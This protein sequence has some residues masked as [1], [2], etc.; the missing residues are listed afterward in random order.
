M[1]AQTPNPGILSPRKRCTQIGRIEILAAT[2][3]CSQLVAR[4]RNLAHRSAMGFGDDAGHPLAGTPCWA[5]LVAHTA[6]LMVSE[7][8][9]S[10]KMHNS[11][12][13]SIVRGFALSSSLRRANQA[14]PRVISVEGTDSRRSDV[15]TLIAAI[16]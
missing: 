1:M 3:A 5:D 8:V 14:E 7:N 13:H 2:A 6:L 12:A 10:L 16:G 15:R 11:E 4:C 9:R